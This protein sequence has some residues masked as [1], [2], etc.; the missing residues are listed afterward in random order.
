VA[1]F[2]TFVFWFLHNSTIWIFISA[3][4]IGYGALTRPTY[5]FL[6]FAVAGYFSIVS[7]LFHWAPL[8]WKE[9]IRASLI[10]ICGSAVI[11]G[12][13]AFVN[14]R[15]VGYFGVAMP[16]LGLT[17]SQ[18]TLRVIER[19]PDEYAAIRETLIKARN[20]E[21]VNGASHTGYSYIW[22]T[23]PELTKITGLDY[24]RL[25]DYMLRI[26][27]LLIQKAPLEYLQDVVWTFGSYWFPTSDKL[28]NLNSRSV[29]LLW[30]VIHFCLVGGFAFNL[31]L[32]VG[33][34]IYIQK[35]K[36]FV[37]QSNNSMLI[38]K[39]RSICLQGFIYGLA[40]TIVIYTATISC[41][42][43]TGNSRYRVPTD[44][45]IIFMLFLGTHIWY[46]LVDLSRS[47]L[48]DT[49]RHVQ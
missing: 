18:K 5:Q 4:T 29:Q 44:A 31:I 43:E 32:L 15:S 11:V 27:L 13:Y 8:K 35:C 6:A 19:L 37:E 47:V 46:R 20:S 3:L 26:N 21:L 38:S 25:S 7:C 49:R 34:A 1:G 10:L 39:L 48:H 24:P 22:G 16:V 40:G 42:V 30:A 12:G 17:L 9:V 41:L 2:V 45:L 36:E 14:Y 23:V 33:A 28:A